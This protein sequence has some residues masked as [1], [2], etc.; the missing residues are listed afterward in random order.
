MILYTEKIQKIR[1]LSV[2][3]RETR[4]QKVL[5]TA[6]LRESQLRINFNPFKRMYNHCHV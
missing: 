4:V 1:V 6:I 2:P 3:A 5:I